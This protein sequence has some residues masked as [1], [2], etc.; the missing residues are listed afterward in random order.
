MR[1]IFRNSGPPIIDQPCPFCLFESHRL[2]S[3][4]SALSRL[5]MCFS[6]VQS[7]D[8]GGASFIRYKANGAITAMGHYWEVHCTAVQ[9]SVVQCLDVQWSAVRPNPH[10]GWPS[11]LR[12]LAKPNPTVCSIACRWRLQLALRANRESFSIESGPHP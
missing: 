3:A 11:G 1:A 9:C 5:P 7:S 4:V 2:P 10:A 6:E 8:R 12:P